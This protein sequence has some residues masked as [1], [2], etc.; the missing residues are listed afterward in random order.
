MASKFKYFNGD[1]HE[2]LNCLKVQNHFETIWRV[3]TIV[4]KNINHVL[5]NKRYLI[6]KAQLDWY[7]DLLKG[8][9]HRLGFI[10]LMIF[11][12]TNSGNVLQN[13]TAITPSPP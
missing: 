13:R 8:Y 11:P 9:H 2:K 1:V 7:H 5:T 12:T 6:S 10:S 4:I 3:L